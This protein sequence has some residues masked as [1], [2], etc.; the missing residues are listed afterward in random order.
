MLREELWDSS[1]AV[2]Q[3]SLAYHPPIGIELGAPESRHEMTCSFGTSLGLRWPNSMTEE[4][5]FSGV[6]VVILA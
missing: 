6:G 4:G 2:S 1:H 3:K 5:L